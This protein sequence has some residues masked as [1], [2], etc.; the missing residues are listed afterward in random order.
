MIMENQMK[1][2]LYS[3]Q[4]N[5]IKKEGYKSLAVFDKS[6]DLFQRGL[7]LYDRCAGSSKAEDILSYLEKT[8]PGRLRSVCVITEP[9][10]VKEYKHPYLNYLVH[11]A[12]VL[13]F[14][15]EQLIKDKI[16]EAIYCKDNRKTVLKDPNFENIYP[17]RLDELTENKYN[18][19]LCGQKKYI[20]HSPWSTIPHYFLVLT[21]GYIPAKYVKKYIT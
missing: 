18:W 13:S 10:P 8:F 11:H 6:S 15:L 16:V 5:K 3:Y 2:Y 7:H 4:Y 21:K 12:D 20:Q 1:V 17:V 19:E 14:D 9:A